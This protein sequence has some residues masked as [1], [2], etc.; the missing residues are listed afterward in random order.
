MLAPKKS[1]G[2]SGQ[3]RDLS[4]AVENNRPPPAPTRLRG[5]VPRRATCR[6]ARLLVLPELFV[7]GHWQR[8]G[9]RT[10]RLVRRWRYNQGRDRE[11]VADA[12]LRAELGQA[13][14]WCQLLQVRDS[15][16]SRAGASGAVAMRWVR[17]LWKN[18]SLAGAP[19]YIEHFSKFSPSPLSMKQFLDFGME[20][21]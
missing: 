16:S 14:G 2:V 9:A 15:S 18:A 6:G 10:N 20:S 4:T 17:A 3:R 21:A 13:E 5:W 1:R 19:K 12:L 8:Q 7:R 11:E